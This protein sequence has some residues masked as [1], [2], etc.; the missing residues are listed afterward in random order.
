MQHVNKLHT[1]LEFKKST[2]LTFSIRLVYKSRAW[3][4]AAKLLASAVALGVNKSLFQ[5]EFYQNR[6]NIV[7]SSVMQIAL[8][9][10]K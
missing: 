10:E 3:A 1:S 7:I 4:E 8:T 5:V 2:N 9:Y 6:N